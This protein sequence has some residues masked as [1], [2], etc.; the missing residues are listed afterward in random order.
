MTENAFDKKRMCVQDGKFSP[1]RSDD[2]CGVYVHI[3]FCKAKC[4][5]CAF[6]S[7]PELGLQ[8]AYIDA[9]EK[10]IFAYA[11]DGRSIADTV[12]IGGGT[13]SCLFGGALT[14]I[15]KALHSAFSL[16][17]DAE[18]TVEVNPESCT[19]EFLREC[20]LCGVNRISM[21][22]QSCDD[23]VLRA[24]NRLHDRNGFISAAKLLKSNGFDNISTDFILGLP[25]QT[26]DDVKNCVNV[27]AEYCTHASVYALTVEEGTPMFAS[28]YRPNDDIVADLYDAACELLAKNGFVRYEVSN[29]ARNGKVSRHNCKY[30]EC[31]PYVG[32]GTAAHGYDGKRTRYFHTDDVKE[33]LRDRSV[34]ITKLSDTDLYNEYVMLRLRTAAGI[35]RADFKTWFGTELDDTA[36]ERLRI[37]TKQGLMIDDGMSVKIAPDKL[38]VMNGIIEELMV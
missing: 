36:G 25:Y 12:Y 16:D 10:E 35:S 29:F 1:P 18:I 33:Y 37:L 26:L 17:D 34:T 21:G 14:R 2:V 22:M 3:P 28:E 23:N 15:F 11:G 30:W 13:P 31:A 38:F 19:D 9:L 6:C 27:A 4:A 7:T 20:R 8:S 24:V 5:Y 32:F